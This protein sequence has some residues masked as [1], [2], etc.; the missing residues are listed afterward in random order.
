MSE[1]PAENP[2]PEITTVLDQE[3]HV[4]GL[5][6]YL[7]TIEKQGYVVIPD[8][9]SKERANQALETLQQEIDPIRDHISKDRNTFRCHNLLAKSRGFDDLVS[10]W[11][12]LAVIQA[13]LG[14]YFQISSAVL[15]DL[16]EGSEPQTLHQ[17]D[18][19]WPLPR[20]HPHFVCNTIIAVEDFTAENGA[21][22]VV[23]G[24]HLWHDQPVRQP[25]DVDA[26]QLEMSAGSIV[27]F[28]GSLWHGGGGNKTSK[29]R[30]GLNFNFNLSYLRQQ[31]N[32]YI[33]VPFEEVIKMPLHLQKV[34][35][36][37][38]CNPGVGPGMVDMRDPLAMV[39][40]THLGYNPRA[41]GMPRLGG[42]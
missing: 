5:Q 7:D 27:F 39:G 15:F 23:P 40:K 17:D 24:S 41:E 36:Y 34:L 16:Q 9:I 29:S 30:K 18:S 26:I 3:V 38:S 32:Q 28:V 22:W 25:P 4:P 11:R 13:V 6:G 21:T 1:V 20:P 37:Q 33:G 31:E 10:D 8:W 12:L 19:I 42:R 2:N 35:G 14:K